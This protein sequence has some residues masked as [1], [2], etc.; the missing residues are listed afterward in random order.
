MPRYTVYRTST[1]ANF[2]GA[3]KDNFNDGYSIGNFTMTV[4]ELADN[5]LDVFEEG[6]FKEMLQQMVSVQP[7]IGR[8]YLDYSIF[9]NKQLHIIKYLIDIF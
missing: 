3:Y 4:V 1:A 2:L 8:V 9:F 5:K 6:V 7:P